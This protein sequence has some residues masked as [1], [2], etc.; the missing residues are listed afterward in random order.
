MQSEIEAIRV[1][2]AAKPR[3]VGWT[4]RRQ[5]IEEVGSVWP[6]ATDV[7]IKPLAAD[8][9][10]GEFSIVPGSDA[11]KVLLFFH[12]GGYCSGSLVSHRRMV[13]EAGRACGARTLAI[14]YRLAPENPFPAALDDALGAWRFLRN[15][16]VDAQKIVV[17]GDSAG[18]GLT[19]ALLQHLRDAGEELPAC[20]WIVSPW[21]DLTLSGATL[22]SKDSA[23][24]I[25]HKPYL[26]ELAQAYVPFGMDR[27]DPR[28]SPLF[29]NLRGLPPLL[30]QAGSEETLLDDAVRFAGAAGAAQV[31][32]NLEIWPQMIH[33]WPM[34]NAHLQAG[35]DALS[36]AGAFIGL[37]IAR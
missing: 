13:T 10:A 22:L 8:G 5:R 14:A 26:E 17:G 24:P 30:I 18:G 34:W 12:G 11:S 25:I 27:K 23:D 31:A 7:A 36:H 32:A 9:V 28:L 1:L 19:L 6:V 37:H 4:E 21:T 2:L 16:G 3:P 35:R 15:S 33:A 29:A 20:A